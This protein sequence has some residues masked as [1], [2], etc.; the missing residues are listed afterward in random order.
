MINQ[1]F[2]QMDPVFGNFFFIAAMLSV[3][4]FFFIRPQAK[5]QKQQDTFVSELQ[6]GQE[7]VT[8]SG[9]IGKVSKIEDN[10]I[11]LQLDQKTF[12][13]VVPHSI[14]MDMTEQ[15]KKKTSVVTAK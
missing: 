12:I 1:I 3:V 7:V 9:I 13:T 10:S 6:K 2:L 5:K 8:S 15:Y 14:S 11:S 4:F